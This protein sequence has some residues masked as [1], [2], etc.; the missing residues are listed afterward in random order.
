[1]AVIVENNEIWLTGTVGAYWWDD[2]FTAVDVAFALAQIGRSTDLVVHLNSGGGLA[3]EGAAIHSQFASHKGRVEIYVEGIAASAASVVAMA[4][5][6]L[7][8]SLG[9][10]LM[11]HDPA[12]LTS[13]NIAEHRKSIDYLTALAA[14]YADIYAEKTGKPVDEMRALMAAE[15]WMTAEEAVAAGFADG[16]TAASLRAANDNQP[17][18]FAYRAYA[19]APA[20]LTALAD[21]RGW[22]PLPHPAVAPTAKATSP[23]PQPTREP[24]MPTIEDL[25]AELAEAKAKIATMD[26]AEK[27]AVTEATARIQ[28]IMT[29]EAAVTHP[30]L[31]RHLAYETEMTAE[32]ALAALAAAGDATASSDPS[33][34]YA[35]RRQSAA[36]LAQPGGGGADRKSPRA[37]L[38]D[39]VSSLKKRR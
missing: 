20:A 13:G 9:A 34:G 2:G 33:A 37:A 11:I 7:V 8:M 12:V 1:M 14:S 21:A 15:T 18:A 22:K 30:A 39:V 25:T 29:A 31:A 38:A 6:R 17:T 24:T 5:D 10:T 27:R 26:A 28:A 3:S 35:A 4:A 23:Q 19:H 36:A 16:T 32:A